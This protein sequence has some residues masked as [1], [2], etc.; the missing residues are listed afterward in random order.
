VR[1]LAALLLLILSSASAASGDVS[2]YRALVEQDLRLATIGYRLAAANAAYCTRKARNP[3]M[4]LHDVAQYPDRKVAAVAF[5]FPGSIAVGG[6]VEKGPA[7]QAGLRSGDG[8][9]TIGSIRIE[10]PETAPQSPTYER[11]GKVKTILAGALERKA[12]VEIGVVRGMTSVMATVAPPL[13]CASDFWVDTRDNLD[14]G[15]DGDRVRM[16]TGLMAFA[17]DDDELA[18]AVAHELAHNILG[19]RQRLAG[20]RR[21]KTKAIYETEIEAD[22]LSVWLM[23]NAGYDTAAAMRFAE[24]YGRKTGLG[25][26]SAATHPRWQKRVEILQAEIALMAQTPSQN[27]LLPPPLLVGG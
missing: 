26:F 22:R 2:A 6:V 1:L 20:I 24:R 4:V 3:G 7:D 10:Y 21:G 27:G 17:S 11:L 15:A 18:A 14:A 13:I 25:I 12:S 19:H 16:T 8:L 9:R 23:A 5:A